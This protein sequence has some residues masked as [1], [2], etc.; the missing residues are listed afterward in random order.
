MNNYTKGPWT[1]HLGSVVSNLKPEKIDSTYDTWNTIADINNAQDAALIASA[2]DMFEAL[3]AALKYDKAISGRAEDGTIK[4]DPRGAVAEGIDL[5]ALYF[6]W[7][8]KSK[9][10]IAKA[11]GGTN[12]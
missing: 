11:K 3:E 1:V 7:I 9:K 5:D 6:D 12:D 4:L 2:P 10:A 8:D